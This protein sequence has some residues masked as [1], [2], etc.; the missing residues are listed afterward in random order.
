METSRK[1]KLSTETSFLPQLKRYVTE[2]VQN[3]QNEEKM[4]EIYGES[5]KLI[6]SRLIPIRIFRH[7]ANFYRTLFISSDR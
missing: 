3:K 1:R 7:D 4:K 2:N 5:G 6:F